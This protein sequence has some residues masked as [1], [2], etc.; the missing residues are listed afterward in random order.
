MN[1]STYSCNTEGLYFLDLLS[2]PE[3]KPY[4]QRLRS[5]KNPKLSYDTLELDVSYWF[6]VL[7]FKRGSKLAFYMSLIDSPLIEKGFV[8]PLYNYGFVV[9]VKL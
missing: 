5:S 3:I 4:F 9:G 1:L 7:N 8:I 2:Y 6:I